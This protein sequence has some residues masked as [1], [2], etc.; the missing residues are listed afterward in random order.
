MD[1]LQISGGRRLSV[2]RKARMARRE[3]E[4]QAAQTKERVASGRTKEDRVVLSRTR[5]S[6]S[7]LDRRVQYLAWGKPEHAVCT[8]QCWA[9]WHVPY[10]PWANT[11]GNAEAPGTWRDFEVHPDSHSLLTDLHFDT[12]TLLVHWYLM[13]PS[14]S[15]P[16]LQ[17][18]VECQKEAGYLIATVT[19]FKFKGPPSIIRR[20]ML[21]HRTRG[22]N[23]KYRFFPSNWLIRENKRNC[24]EGVIWIGRR[25]TATI[26]G[27]PW[28]LTITRANYLT[29]EALVYLPDIHNHPDHPNADSGSTVRY[30]KSESAKACNDLSR[31]RP[32]ESVTARTMFRKICCQAALMSGAMLVGN[33]HD[34]VDCNT[35]KLRAT[36]ARPLMDVRRR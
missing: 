11:H 12:S 7:S 35:G 31:S 8:R 36:N 30:N 27:K 2:T 18:D 16:E 26:T 23:T 14:P 17:E 34:A 6:V 21:R 10:G 22:R 33:S 3:G 20:A 4:E 28:C 24:L 13:A 5:V 32:V 15:M 19:C 1:T 9:L 29:V 25:V